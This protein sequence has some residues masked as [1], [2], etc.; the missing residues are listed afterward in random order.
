MV[1]LHK[2]P[3]LQIW[4][5]SR[6]VVVMDN[7]SIHREARVAE[8]INSVGC[9]V[10]FTPPYCPWFQP[11]EEAFNQLKRVCILFNNFNYRCHIQHMRR[12]GVD[13]D[14]EYDVVRGISEAFA[15]VK[16]IHCQHYITHAGYDSV[17]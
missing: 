3:I 9:I 4:P 13:Y 8:L 12:N 16:P 5:S 11:C 15:E 7:A 1:V 6:S 14:D 2:V 17:S 10:A